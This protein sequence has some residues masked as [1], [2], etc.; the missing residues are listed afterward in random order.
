MLESVVI[1]FDRENKMPHN[2]V[3]SRAVSSAP[4]LVLAPQAGCGETAH[5]ATVR[6]VS[7][8]VPKEKFIS[9][10]QIN[11]IIALMRDRS[12]SEGVT[13]VLIGGVAM[14]SYG[15]PRLTKDIDFALPELL[16]MTGWV[17]L[18]PINFGGEAYMAPNGGKLDLVVRADEYKELYD[19]ALANFI[20]TTEGVSIVTPEHLATMKLAANE[21]K[22]I[23]DLKWL[24]K[25]SD[26]VDRKAAGN[27]VYW[28][29]G[30]KFAQQMF[31]RICDETD[32][33]LRREG[34]RDETSYP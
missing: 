29:V 21:P 25:Q 13:A 11:E 32:A 15:S 34:P 4:H 18:G 20:V 12:I 2:P 33:E 28:F 17:H 3:S 31:D 7:A 30:G 22:H 23:L 14:Q 6:K 16:P 5:D 10:E 27:L 24:L 8:F 1:Q 26:L 9:V 19:H